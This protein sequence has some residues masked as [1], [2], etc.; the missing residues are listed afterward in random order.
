MCIRD[1]GMDALIEAHDE[2]EVA[3]ALKA[4]AKIVGVNNRDL[5]TFKVDMNNSI[6]CV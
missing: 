2:E 6:R 1:R 5:K 4:G 3:R